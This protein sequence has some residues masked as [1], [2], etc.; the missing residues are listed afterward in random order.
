MERMNPVIGDKWTTWLRRPY[1]RMNQGTLRDSDTGDM[2]PLGV[3]C[4]IHREETGDGHWNLGR[5]FCGDNDS[6]VFGLPKTVIQ[7]AGLKDYV[8]YPQLGTYNISEW[9]DG[10]QHGTRIPIAPLEPAAIANLIEE[11]L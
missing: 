3:L 10:K 4:E 1:Y 5:Y 6:A 7:W 8:A 9:A 2:C 11:Y